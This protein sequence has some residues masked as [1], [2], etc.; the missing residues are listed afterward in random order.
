[1]DRFFPRA[2]EETPDF[3]AGERQNRRHEARQAVGH[4]EHRRLRRPPLARSG[5]KRVHPI[6]RHVD[7]ERAQVDGGERVQRLKDRAVVVRVVRREDPKRGVCVARKDVPIDFFELRHVDEIGG[8]IEV[9]QI[10]DQV[11]HRV[12]DLPVRLDDA[13][14]NLLAEAH[15]LRVVAHRHPQTDDVGAALLDDVVR[16]D[17]IAERLRHLAAVLGHDEAVREDLPERRA[18]ARAQADEQRA[19]EPAAMLVA[20]FEIDVGGPRQLGPHREHRLMARPRVE[21]DVENVHLALEMA[22]AALGTREAGGNEILRRTLVPRVG[23]VLLEHGGRFLDERRRDDR[24]AARRAVHRRN[25][26]APHALPR[27]APVGTVGDHVVHAV[28]AP[29]RDP[30]H[31]AID[32]LER[33]L[34]QRAPSP[35]PGA[36]SPQRFVQRD[37]P[38]RRR[39]KDDRIVTAPAVRILVRERLA[40]PQPSSFLQRIGDVRVRVEHALAAEQFH[41][42]EEM[43][44]RSDRRVDLQPVLHAG[45]EVVGAVAGRGVDGA[46]SR[47]ERDVL[48]QH[49]ERRAR[50]QRMLK[51]DVFELLAFHPRDRR[52]ERFPDRCRHFFRQR[53]GD[54][55]RASLD[56]VRAVVEVRMKRDREVRRNRPRRRRPD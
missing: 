25:R 48:A 12:A 54:D 31:V 15:F 26:H 16:L 55:D 22:A 49:A 34:P 51:A 24:L 39:E 7:V 6:L 28:A 47:L 5:R 38:L 44:R 9:V 52:A 8:R 30:P 46:R 14:E 56:G 50:V 4:Q 45:R 41:R 21:P 32:V 18:A 27:D 17:R 23:A 20:P 43:S 35:Q 19:L 13:R 3:V 11:P 42:V 1:M 2:G 40:M 36:P 29:R 37:E 10:R 53:L 33:G